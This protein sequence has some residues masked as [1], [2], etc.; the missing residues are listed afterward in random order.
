MMFYVKIQ[1]RRFVCR[2]ALFMRSFTA[3]TSEFAWLAV[4]TKSY[5]LY[6]KSNSGGNMLFEQSVLAPRKYETR[7]LNE[8]LPSQ[9]ENVRDK[10][11]SNRFDYR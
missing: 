11:T 10:T 2:D 5:V 7:N 3:M 9:T 1:M 4:R 6:M 8:N